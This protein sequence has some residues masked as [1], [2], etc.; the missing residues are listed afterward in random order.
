MEYVTTMVC[1]AVK[2][3]PVIGIIHR[4]FQNVTGIDCYLHFILEYKLVVFD[5]IFIIFWGF[6]SILL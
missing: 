5:N 4:P 3:K 6:R 2:G 1:V